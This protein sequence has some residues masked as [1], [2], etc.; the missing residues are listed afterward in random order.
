[1]IGRVTSQAIKV[2]DDVLH[3]RSSPSESLLNRSLQ[4]KP[5]EKITNRS[6]FE[7]DRF[8]FF[9]VGPFE[10]GTAAPAEKQTKN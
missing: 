3:H 1:M 6:F 7:R 2:I 10:K 9:Y 8:L 4:T 5:K